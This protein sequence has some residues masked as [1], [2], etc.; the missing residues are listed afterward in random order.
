MLATLGFA[1][2]VLGL[3]VISYRLE[4]N[5]RA[6]LE[7]S[8]DRDDGLNSFMDL[9]DRNNKAFVV[10]WWS[11][12]HSQD[13]HTANRGYSTNFDVGITDDFLFTTHVGNYLGM[14]ITRK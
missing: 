7:P 11:E 4:N 3:L 12:Q 1:I 13:D 5:R 10:S 9:T 2:L 14:S 6:R 8:G